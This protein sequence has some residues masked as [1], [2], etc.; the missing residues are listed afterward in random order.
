MYVASSSER[1]SRKLVLK[2]SD[3]C[4]EG[5]RFYFCLELRLFSLPHARD[6]MIII[7]LHYRA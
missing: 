5:R 6:M 3:Q 1:V 7:S 2:A 4:A